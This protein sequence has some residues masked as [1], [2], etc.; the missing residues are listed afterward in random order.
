MSAHHLRW[1]IV[2]QVHS[3]YQSFDDA[4][5]PQPNHASHRLTEL[6]D[7][8]WQADVTADNVAATQRLG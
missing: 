6:D 1:K 5:G 7:F 4:R 8:R 3:E 2:R